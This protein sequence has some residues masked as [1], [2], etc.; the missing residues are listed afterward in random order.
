MDS[1]S[2]VQ[3]RA[4]CGAALAVEIFFHPRNWDRANPQEASKQQAVDIA[5]LYHLPFCAGHSTSS[6]H[7]TA[8]SPV[9]KGTG[10]HVEADPNRGAD[11]GQLAD[12]YDL[13]PTDVRNTG[14]MS[15]RS[16]VAAI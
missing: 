2:S 7:A 3:I 10:F 9:R 12:C 11:L 4:S 14:S 5:Y 8:I 15:W 6:D 1:C 13:L 16:G